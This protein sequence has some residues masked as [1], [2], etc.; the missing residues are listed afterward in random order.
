MY[1]VQVDKSHRLI[2]ALLEKVYVQSQKQ[3]VELVPNLACLNTT[4]KYQLGIFLKNPTL[5][6]QFQ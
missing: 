3:V 4:Y 1:I 6:K 2:R 5:D